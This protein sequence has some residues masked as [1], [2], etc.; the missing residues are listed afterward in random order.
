ML[1]QHKWRDKRTTIW[2]HGH[3]YASKS[4]GTDKLS[5]IQRILTVKH[6][7]V[8]LRGVHLQRRSWFERQRVYSRYLVE[9]NTDIAT[10]S[11]WRGWWTS[12]WIPMVWNNVNHEWRLEVLVFSVVKVN[13]ENDQTL[14]KCTAL[15]FLVT[16]DTCKHRGSLMMLWTIEM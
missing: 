4:H 2:T 6:E 16:L 8:R 11:L 9:R 3:E 15:S 12:A 1:S 5:S 14:C 13:G 10:W 7:R